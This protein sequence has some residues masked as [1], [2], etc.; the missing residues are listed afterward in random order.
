VAAVHYSIVRLGGC[1]ETRPAPSPK[2]QRSM[3]GG[4]T[5]RV[6]GVVQNLATVIVPVMQRL[7]KPNLT[8][9]ISLEPIVLVDF[10]HDCIRIQ[11]VGQ[12]VE[13]RRPFSI[14]NALLDDA[15]RHHVWATKA[16][17]EVIA[18]D[19]LPQYSAKR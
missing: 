11:L 3:P 7:R 18:R 1:S 15:F 16:L 5:P 14:D 6:V 12:E 2:S 8:R 10:S 19:S 4:S 13:P 17:V 9:S